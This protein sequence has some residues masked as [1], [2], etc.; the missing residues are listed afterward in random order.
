MR[1]MMGL[2][3]PSAGKIYLGLGDMPELG[4]DEARY[5][6][7]LAEP[8]LMLNP[9]GVYL[10]GSLMAYLKSALRA[11][12]YK[13]ILLGPHS[14]ERLVRTLLSTLR[15]GDWLAD[16]GLARHEDERSPENPKIGLSKIP[17]RRIACAK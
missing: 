2:E 10:Y 7:E 1:P 5:N 15:K 14:H 3:H 4:Q 9:H 16:Q 11:R 17:R 8:I 13:G 6:K 12:H